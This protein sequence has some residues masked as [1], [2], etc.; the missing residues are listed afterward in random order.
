MGPW[1]HL[2][3]ALGSL[4][5]LGQGTL[6]DLSPLG[7]QGPFGALFQGVCSS[8]VFLWLCLH[9]TQVSQGPW[10]PGAG[11]SHTNPPLEKACGGLLGCTFGDPFGAILAPF[12]IL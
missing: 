12:G 7:P 3:Q 8:A 5:A 10:G 4:G 9:C 11:C 2:Y 6:G 1:A